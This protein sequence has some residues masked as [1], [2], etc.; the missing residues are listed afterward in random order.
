MMAHHDAFASK[1]PLHEVYD[2]NADRPLAT[3]RTSAYTEV[4]T[5]DDTHLLYI[6]DRIPNG[7]YPVPKDSPETNS[8]WV[9][10]MT[11]AKK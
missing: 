2:K 6:Y 8:V 5:L 9:V 7:W 4:I 1:D 11:I 10:R 3:L